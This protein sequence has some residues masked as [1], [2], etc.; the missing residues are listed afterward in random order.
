MERGGGETEKFITFIDDC[1]LR[2]IYDFSFTTMF[3]SLN[4]LLAAPTS[5]SSL[6]LTPSLYACFVI[7]VAVVLFYACFMLILSTFL[8]FLFLLPLS[9]L[10][11]WL[12]SV[13]FTSSFL[14]GEG[15]YLSNRIDPLL[16]SFLPYPA[17]QLTAKRG[18]I[19][20]SLNSEKSF[21]PIYLKSSWN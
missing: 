6:I 17:L 9:F 18:P 2:E 3:S 11:S 4:R 1:K 16:M 7:V 19:K 13:F 10:F 14:M 12:D 20:S 5:P 8:A 15:G 21:L